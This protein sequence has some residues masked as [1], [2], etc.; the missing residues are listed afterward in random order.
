MTLTQAAQQMAAEM[1][2]QPEVLA[3][4]AARFAELTDRV[5]GLTDGRVPGVAFLARGS[6]DNAALLGRYAV[7]ISAGVPTSLVAPSILTSYHGRP[8]RFAGWLVVAL[9]QSGRTPEIID[10]AARFRSCGAHVVAITNDAGSPLAAEA[11]LGIALEAAAELAVPATKTVTGQML[12]TLVIANALGRP[13]ITAAELDQIPA[14]MAEILG[15]VDP[16]RRAAAA[17]APRERMA[18]VARGACYA[19]ALETALKLQET[20]G[21]LA[22]GFSTA[23]FRH[24]PI[25]VCGPSTPALLFTGSGP[26]DNDTRDLRPRLS[27]AGAL[28]VVAG[29]GPDSQIGWPEVSGMADCL[30]ATV[31]G[32]Q[33]AFHVALARG[34]D[35]D[36]PAGLSKVTLTH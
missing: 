34:V 22:H 1:A 21:I 4:L 20:T 11:D 15:D 18:V 35:P 33:L 16:I 28:V 27:Q 10:V 19:A 3:R 13:A 8:E 30:L 24:G 9:S 32:Q 25:A 17:V 2:E 7:E 29:T 14:A 36:S 31:R 23:D 6:S 5:R 12:A 26:A